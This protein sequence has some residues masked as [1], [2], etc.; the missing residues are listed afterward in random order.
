VTLRLADDIDVSRG[1][2]L[3]AA[4]DAPVPTQDVAAVLCWLGDE[5]LRP[6][7]RLLLKHGARTVRA[8]VRQIGGVLDL[9]TV[10]SVPADALR[11]N[12]LGSVTLRVAQALPVEPYAASRRGGSFLLVDDHDGRTLAAGMVGSS[13]PTASGTAPSS[14]AV[15]AE[16]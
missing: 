5:P 2:V 9:E 6:G 16:D 14:A 7:R 3:A 1:D 8:V 10:R 4:A 13:L 12:D 15:A 11:L